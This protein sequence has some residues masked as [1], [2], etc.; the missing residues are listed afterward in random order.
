LTRE[1]QAGATVKT[2]FAVTALA[3]LTVLSFVAF[4]QYAP[5]QAE[6]AF[7]RFAIIPALIVSGAAGLPDTLVRMFGHVFFHYGPLHLL[8]NGLA[9]MQAAP[10]LAFRIG[11]LR[12][13]LLFFVSALGGALAFI[14][15]SPPR[16][17]GL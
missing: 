15:F 1:E 13:V 16:R 8:M 10:F 7:E 9:Y 4:G 11:D 14:L 3:A 17:L 12:F 6:P 5:L 2:S